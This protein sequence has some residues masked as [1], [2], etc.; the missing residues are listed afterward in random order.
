MH[1]FHCILFFGLFLGDL[2]GSNEGIYAKW[3]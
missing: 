1:L 2:L 3:S